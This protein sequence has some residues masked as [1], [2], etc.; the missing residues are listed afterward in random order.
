MAPDTK[1]LWMNKRYS[2]QRAFFLHLLGDKCKKC[3]SK[4]DLQIDHR[5]PA[6]KKFHISKIC[7]RRTVVAMVA[8]VV[9]ECQLLCA[10]HHREKSA[11][12]RSLAMTGTF[13]HGTMYAWMRQRCVCPDCSTAKWAWHDKRNAARRKGKAYSPRAERMAL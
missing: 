11:R 1:K 7:T 2:I 6:A 4:E 13:R 3:G 5:D 10:K 12:E 9:N 8:E